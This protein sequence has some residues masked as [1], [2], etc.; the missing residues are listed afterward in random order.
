MS[1]MLIPRAY[2]YLQTLEA[3]VPPV[4][5]AVATVT[6]YR[7]VIDA[8]LAGPARLAGGAAR[9]ERAILKEDSAVPTDVIAELG[10][11]VTTT[12][13]TSTTYTTDITSSSA[14]TYAY[15]RYRYYY[16]TITWYYWSYYYTYHYN[17]LPTS[18]ST[19][20]ST[21]YTRYTTISVYATASNE[22][23]SSLSSKSATL[24]LPTPA[25][26]TTALASE[27]AATTGAAAPTADDAANESQ[28]PTSSGTSIHGRGWWNWSTLAYG[29]IMVTTL[30]MAVVL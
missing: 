30:V 22:A 15:T 25:A 21:R 2:E 29:L 24:S 7:P 14:T 10:S 16:W 6:V 19:I 23:S 26:A 18:T 27:T 12:R 17:A 3:A 28:G 11:S 13:T 5:V 4:T 1:R 8:A 20:T 9:K